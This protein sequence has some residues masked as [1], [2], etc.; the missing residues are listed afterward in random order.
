VPQWIALAL[1][2]LG[3]V[4]C[5]GTR[6]ESSDVARHC[7]NGKPISG[8]ELRGALRHEGFSADCVDTYGTQ[9]ANE[10]PTE[11]SKKPESEGTVLC[12][13]TR[14]SPP[15]MARRP[16]HVFVYGSIPTR[17]QPGRTAYVA[18]V[19]CTLYLDSGTRGDAPV[20][21]QRAFQILAARK[22]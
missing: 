15:R 3:C 20:R 9:V 21:L 22:Y 12:D 10:T 13:V 7:A 11:Q 1:V 4:A 19:E 6:Q 16:H 2:A 14:H 18:N 8:G 5:G 17:S